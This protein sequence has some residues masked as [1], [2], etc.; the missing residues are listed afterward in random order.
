LETAVIFVL[1]AA[2]N[3][4]AVNALPCFALGV[5]WNFSEACF[6]QKNPIHFRHYR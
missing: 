6:R 5:A 3:V 1:E 4:Q 2:L